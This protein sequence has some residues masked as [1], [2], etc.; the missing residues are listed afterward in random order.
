MRTLT[1]REALA[2]FGEAGIGLLLANCTAAQPSSATLIPSPALVAPK[3]GGVLRWIRARDITSFDPHMV[4]SEGDLV[5]LYPMFS[6]LLQPDP[7]DG[8]KLIPDLAEAWDASKDGL[9]HTF[10]LVKG[11]QFHDGTQLTSEDVKFS[12]ERLAQS[13]DSVRAEFYGVIADVEAPDKSTVRVRLKYPSGA[14]LGLM[15][16]GYSAIVPR[17]VVEAKGNLKNEPVGSG[18][19]MY[20]DRRSGVSLDLRRNPNYFVRDRPYLDGIKFLVMQ[21]EATR[22]AAIQ[23]GEAHVTGIAGAGQISP[24]AAASL[25]ATMK[26][27]ITVWRFRRMAV[28]SFFMNTTRK[29]WQDLRVRK[30]VHLALDRQAMAKVVFEGALIPSAFIGAPEWAIPQDELLQMP[31][32]RQPKDADR[33]EAKRLLSDAG[34]PDG[35]ATTILTQNE[36]GDLRLAT[37]VQ[38]QLASIGI[39]AK[40]DLQESAA[41]KQKRDLQGD[42]DTMQGGFGSE[43]AEPAYVFNYRDHTGGR[44]NYSRTTFSELDKVID[45][46][47]GEADPV[48]RKAG[49]LQ[50]QRKLLELVPHAP[51]G[52]EPRLYA[53]W[54]TVRNWMPSEGRAETYKHQDTWLA[55]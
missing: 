45:E 4:G 5:S 7:L 18:P 15:G 3:R 39:K 42:Y 34:F 12:L 46:F 2:L 32:Y 37:F 35:F 25:E 1:R 47:T 44:Q 31:G 27:R 38:D 36:A 17:H 28:Q 16:L 19:F 20:G 49:S 6:Q 41:Y 26:D 11:V 8:S 40:L 51:S 14:F 10:H 9:T 53:A 33:A 29:P 52:T 30:A 21:D 13:K 55:D 43:L 54:R 22:N 48:K 24:S 23:T 50:I